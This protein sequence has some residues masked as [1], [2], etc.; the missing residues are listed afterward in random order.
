M[1]AWHPALFALAGIAIG[2]VLFGSGV[3]AALK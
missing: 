1:S 3:C 2:M